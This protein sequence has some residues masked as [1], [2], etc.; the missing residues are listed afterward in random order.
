MTQ[1]QPRQSGNPVGRPKGSVNRQLKMLREAAE[2]VLPLVLERALAGD[3]DAQKL[4]I[5]RGIPRMKSIAPAEPFI[6]PEGS[7]AEQMQALLQQVADGELSAIAA[8]QAMGMVVAATKAKE[9]EAHNTAA[10]KL[11]SQSCGSAYLAAIQAKYK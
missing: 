5:E 9:I 10:R 1:F 4:I 2:Q 8:T 11:S 7:L 3:A 6:L